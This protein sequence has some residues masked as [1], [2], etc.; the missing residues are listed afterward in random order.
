MEQRTFRLVHQVARSNAAKFCLE[1]P[2]GWDVII[3]PHK[4]D[5]SLAQNRLAFQWYMER[6]EQQGTTP[7][8]EHRLAK[9]RWGCPLLIAVDAEFADFYRRGIEPL[10]YERRIIA[11]QW[12]PVTRLFTVKMMTE[13][14]E[15]MERE[16]AMQGII[17]TRPDDMY[18]EAMGVNR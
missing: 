8:Y 3:R 2:E 14:L 9:L 5:R 7:E 11:M 16:S 1:A 4:K 6:A 13:Y 10:D 15:T 12:V 18:W 17:L